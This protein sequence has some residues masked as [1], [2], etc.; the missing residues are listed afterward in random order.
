MSHVS[1]LDIVRN[2][3]KNDPMRNIPWLANLRGDFKLC[4]F[5]Y[6]IYTKGRWPQEM[7]KHLLSHFLE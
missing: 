7:K 3:G 1:H 4:L 2:R 5:V 6:L